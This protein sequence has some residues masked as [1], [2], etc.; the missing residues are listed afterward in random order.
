MEKKKMRRKTL[1]GDY[2]A[3]YKQK[4]SDGLIG[5]IADGS[6]EKWIYNVYNGHHKLV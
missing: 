2:F 1:N 4:I 6:S 5:F 3:M